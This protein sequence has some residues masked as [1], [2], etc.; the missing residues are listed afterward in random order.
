MTDT[1]I[2]HSRAA[3]SSNQS[4]EAAAQDDLATFL[5]GWVSACLGD[6]VQEL[7]TMIVTAPASLKSAFCC[8]DV[9]AEEIEVV[10]Q[11]IWWDIAVKR[12]RAGR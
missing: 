5:R 1:T 7:D 12:M 2:S 10:V 4:G 9:M 3:Y 11:R 6:G 8:Y